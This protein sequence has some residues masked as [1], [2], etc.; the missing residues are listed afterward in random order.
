MVRR[1]SI[2]RPPVRAA[3]SLR[4]ERVSWRRCARESARELLRRCTRTASAFLVRSQPNSPFGESAVWGFVRTALVSHFRLAAMCHACRRI[5][6][7]GLASAIEQGMGDIRF[8]HLRLGCSNCRS[9]LF[10]ALTHGSSVQLV[11][12]RRSRASDDS[13]EQAVTIWQRS[14][15][16]HH[17]YV[18][19]AIDLF[20][21][22]NAGHSI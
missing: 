9:R 11:R 16:H 13:R 6:D 2:E 4:R 12:R 1:S 19:V 7:V 8:V 5:T 22:A 14:N 15:H 10:D 18:M 3:R 17:R 21:V 20:P